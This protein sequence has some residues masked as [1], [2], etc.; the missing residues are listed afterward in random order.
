MN[1]IVIIGCSNV[2]MAYAHNIVLRD[3]NVD[4]LALIDIQEDKIEGEAIDLSHTLA[5]T[6][7][8]INIKKGDYSDVADANLVVICAGRNQKVGETRQQL[9]DSN[10]KIL[11]DILNKCQSH[12]FKGIYIIASN[13]VDI[14][15]LYAY[16]KLKIESS[17]VIGSGTSLDTARLQYIVGRKLEINPKYINAFVLGEHGDSEMIAW[18]SATIA[19]KPITDYLTKEEMQSITFDV[20]NSAYEIINK[21][22]YTNYGIGSALFTITYAILSNEA[23]ILPVSNYDAKNDL[24]YSRPA[25]INKEGIKKVLVLNLSKSDD[26]KLNESIKYLKSVKRDLNI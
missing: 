22:G 21:K 24:Y 25:I 11:D 8:Y 10:I 13:P 20:K 1:K 2:G 14:L 9:I 26:K 17:K 23:I 6:N 12:N 5:F 4:E 19:N 16:K 3:C 15:S 7:N 18:D